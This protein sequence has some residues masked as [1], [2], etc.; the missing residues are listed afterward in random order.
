MKIIQLK[1]ENVKRIEAV[2]ITPDPGK[3]LVLIGGQNA[4]GKSSVMD[5]ILYGIAGGREIKE[6]PVRKGEERAVIEID[7]GDLKIR[8]TFSANGNM[9]LHVTNKDG[10]KL[11]SPQAILDSLLCKVGFDPLEFSRQKPTDQYETLRALAGLDFTQID[12][13]RQSAYDE[14][15][16]LGRDVKTLEGQ[17]AGLAE[18]PNVPAGEISTVDIMQKWRDADAA[19][20]AN[21]KVREG[22]VVLESERNRITDNLQRQTSFTATLEEEIRK[23]QQRLEIQKAEVANLERQLADLTARCT[24]RESAVAALRD[25]DLNPFKDQVQRAETVNRQVR[26]NQQRAK[27]ASELAA[28]RTAHAELDHKI[29][30]L[31][32]E[33]R[34][35][36]SKAKMP[37]DGLTFEAGRVLFKG[38]PFS[39]ISSAEQLKISVAV[40]LALNPK[41]KVLL[42]RDGSLLDEQSL[43]LVGQLAD[44]A[45]GQVWVERV[46]TDGD[47]SVIIEDGRVKGADLS[48]EVAKD[49]GLP[50]SGPKNGLPRAARKAK[51]FV[52]DPNDLIP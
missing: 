35:M 41:L 22:L 21:D 16:I 48:Q 19:N 13:K 10:A 25:I 39:E 11:S 44:Q 15:T 45:G 51:E 27:V 49:N 30:D 24:E 43:G 8:R 18:H 4:Q 6:I 52:S 9:S 17:L 5:S 29:E 14:R 37:I 33:K 12:Q 42:I 38:I 31:D 3:A 23:A 7:L 50:Q 34:R 20:K 46:G 40:G 1:S 28:K 26:Q 32:V 2:A 47:L 36:I